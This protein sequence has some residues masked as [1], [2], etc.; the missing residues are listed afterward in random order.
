MMHLLYLAVLQIDCYVAGQIAFNSP[1][2]TNEQALDAVVT[3]ADTTEVSL[4]DAVHLMR[5][6]LSM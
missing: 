2:S 6:V 3:L 1:G 5:G 4:T